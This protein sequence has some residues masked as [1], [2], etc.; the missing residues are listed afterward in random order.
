VRYF[1]VLILLSLSLHA[2]ACDVTSKESVVKIAG[3]LA[4]PD[5]PQTAD[6]LAIVR[7]ESAFK[8]H[9]RNKSY[10]EDSRGLMQ[11]NGG[12]Y[13]PHWNMA[14]GI[15]QLR[16]NYLRFHSKEAAVKAYNIGAKNYATGK[17]KISA[18][19][20]YKKYLHWHELY[21][22]CGKRQHWRY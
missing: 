11:I 12:P 18:K 4:Y 10:R 2:S 13:D 20:Y 1:L 7:V 16:E 8:I 14:I 5:F 3:R 6:I 22:A 17:Y 9:A 19:I 15:G 21:V